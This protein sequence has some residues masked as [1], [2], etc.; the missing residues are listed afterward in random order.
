MLSVPTTDFGKNT[1]MLLCVCV[2]LLKFAACRVHARALNY[3]HEAELCLIFEISLNFSE[4]ALIFL[5]VQTG[6]KTQP[7]IRIA[8]LS[9]TKVSV[10]SQFF[11]SLLI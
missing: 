11:F 8:A 5:T 1:A 3:R 2:S 10:L 7:E 9:P 4:A 6:E